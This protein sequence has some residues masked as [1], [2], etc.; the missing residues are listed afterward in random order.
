MSIGK[1][2]LIYFILKSFITTFL[3]FFL[4]EI[5]G[6]SYFKYDDFLSYANCEINSPNGFYSLFLC[7]IN[8][9]SI[10]DPRV[11]I[12]ALLINTTRDFLLINIIAKIK[13]LKFKGLMF[14]VCI[15]ALHPY[16][17]LYHARLTTSSFAVVG[18]LLMYYVLASKKQ[19]N[20]FIDLSF[21][22]LTGFRNSLA[23][24]FLPYY[25]WEIIR[26]LREIINK[27]AN[28]DSYFIKNTISFMAIVYVVMLSG[29]YMT[30]FVTSAN[31]YSLDVPY[32]TQYLHTPY[33]LL[34]IL[35]AIVLVLVSHTISL[36]GFR[37]AAY[38]EFPDFFIPL[39][40]IAYFHIFA[41]VILAIAH[42]AG[43]YYFLKSHLSQDRRYIIFIIILLPTLFSVAHLRY[44]LPFIPLALI[45]L[46]MLV[47]K[48]LIH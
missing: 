1:L 44:F 42:G 3:I 7:A 47:E 48:K 4:P 46:S 9:N 14:F 29:G 8:A 22:I 12:T 13:L 19:T 11:I 40:G 17:A 18:V 27:N 30:S 24:L 10:S 45:G 39:D 28:F 31:V 15:L 32:F 37:E 2:F 20:I 16:L 36:L 21:I 33:E 6:R 23:G 43:F 35:L 38:T 41:G 25:I 26:Q 34:N 5:F